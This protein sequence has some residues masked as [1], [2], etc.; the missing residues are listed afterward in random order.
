MEAIAATGATRAQQLAYGSINSL[1]WAL[2]LV[3]VVGPGVL[4]GASLQT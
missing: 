2:L 3:T 1:I 4:I